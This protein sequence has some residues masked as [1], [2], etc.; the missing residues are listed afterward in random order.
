[1][2]YI[3]VLIP[4][5]TIDRTHLCY[6]ARNSFALDVDDNID[7]TSNSSLLRGNRNA[8]DK[9]LEAEKRIIRAVTMYS[10]AAPSMA[11]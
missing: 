10:G 11:G 5:P 7:C 4:I 6:G 3:V 9:I 1:M 2:R 8:A